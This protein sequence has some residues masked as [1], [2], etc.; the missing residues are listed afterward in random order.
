[1]CKWQDTA[2]L[3]IGKVM[4][5]CSFYVVICERQGTV[6]LRLES[7]VCCKARYNPGNCSKNKI[8]LLLLCIICYICL[9]KILTRFQIEELKYTTNFMT[10]QQSSFQAEGKK[11]KHPKTKRKRQLVFFFDFYYFRTIWGH[12]NI[13]HLGF[14]MTSGTKLAKTFHCKAGATLRIDTDRF[15]L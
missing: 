1:M 4:R 12:L 7:S 6:V 10:Q 5:S 9:G 2:V 13:L 3:W 15:Q 8:Y 14:V 11:K